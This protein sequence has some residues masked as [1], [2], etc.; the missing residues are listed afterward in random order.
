MVRL[1]MRTAPK[2]ITPQVTPPVR[3]SL[4][5][6][7][8]L[9]EKEQLGNAEIRLKFR[10]KDCMHLHEHY[11]DPTLAQGLVEPTISD[12]PTNRLQKYRL[13]AKKRAWLAKKVAGKGRAYINQLLRPH[14]PS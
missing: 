11:I 8:H 7:L 4:T 1:P 6:F 9:L 2:A 5:V 10:L 13:I 12:K 3:P 14:Q